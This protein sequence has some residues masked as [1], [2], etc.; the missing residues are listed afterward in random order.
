MIF[1]TMAKIISG[2]YCRL[3]CQPCGSPT[4]WFAGKGS[5]IIDGWVITLLLFSTQYLKI[6]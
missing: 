3:G 2:D 6:V 5:P 4:E 1:N